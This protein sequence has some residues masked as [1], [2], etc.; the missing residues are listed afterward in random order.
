MKHS[1]GGQTSDAVHASGGHLEIHECDMSS[2]GGA[3]VQIK[4]RGTEAELTWCHAHDCN[5]SGFLVASQAH[6]LVEDCTANDNGQA[7]Y[8]VLEAKAELRR[9]IGYRNLGGIGV[10]GKGSVAT[11]ERNQ[12]KGNRQDNLHVDK[13]CMKKVKMT[14]NVTE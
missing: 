2:T 7:G 1:G 14:E 5:Q 4:G 13:S 12:L 10:F 9:N 8:V 11:L 6:A 3:G